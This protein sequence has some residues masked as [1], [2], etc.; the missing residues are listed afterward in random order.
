[1]VG[2]DPVEREDR[3]V[4]HIEAI[5]TAW[6]ADASTFQGRFSKWEDMVCRP[7]P[8]QPSGVPIVLG[9]GGPKAARRAASRGDGMLWPGSLGLQ[10]HDEAHRTKASQ[11]VDALERG[12]DEAGRARG[13][14]ELTVGVSARI[15]DDDLD[16]FRDLGVARVLVSARDVTAGDVERLVERLAS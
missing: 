3:F 2:V 8:R 10:S 6:S 14:V 13:E 16:H 7:R 15:T 9:A 5:R 1:A 4:E 12:L 11:L